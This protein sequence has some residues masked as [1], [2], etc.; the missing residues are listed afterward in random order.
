MIEIIKESRIQ[1]CYTG[2]FC[3]YRYEEPAYSDQ[4]RSGYD[5]SLDRAAPKC[6]TPAS[7]RIIGGQETQRGEFPWAVALE[8][9]WGFQY[10]GG[11]LINEK[12]RDSFWK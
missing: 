3:G 7:D 2:H 1:K 4:V 6:G 5:Y 12:V 10:C 8:M 9:S 11:S